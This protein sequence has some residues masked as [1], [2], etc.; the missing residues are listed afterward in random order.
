MIKI[1]RLGIPEELTPEQEQE[2]TDIFKQTNSSVWKQAYIIAQLS[3]M[4]F[5]KCCYSEQYLGENSAYLEVEHFYPKDLYPDLVVDWNNLLPA[6]KKSNTTK[7]AI[8]PHEI[9]LINPCI[10][11]PKEHLQIINWRIRSKTEKGKNSIDNYALNS[12]HFSDPRMRIANNLLEQLEDL[13]RDDIT[14]IRKRNRIKSILS[15]GNR[16]K[17]FSAFVSTIILKDP[18]YNDLK[19]R[20]VEVGL[21]DSEFISLEMELKY[22]A[23]L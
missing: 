2:L 4:S 3:K 21:W 6:C 22:C 11:D 14:K 13:K 23:L 17:E 15:N 16:K 18:L 12:K 10:D 9:D 8:D 20:L 1:E 7:G 19:N 5:S